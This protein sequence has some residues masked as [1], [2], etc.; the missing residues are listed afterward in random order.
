M[1]QINIKQQVRFSKNYFSMLLITIKMD[2]LFEC[3]RSDILNC[4]CIGIRLS[5]LPTRFAHSQPNWQ[6]YSC[7]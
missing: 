4:S 6:K 2:N 5:F 1:L 3:R 7:M